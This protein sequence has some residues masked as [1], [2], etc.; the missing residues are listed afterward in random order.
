M[1]RESIILSPFLLGAIA[2]AITL[3]RDHI[4]I[5][6]PRRRTWSSQELESTVFFLKINL[7]RY[8]SL[9][10]LVDSMI[11]VGTGARR[12]SGNWSIERILYVMGLDK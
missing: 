3:R 5:S 7:G 2:F 12:L 1:V 11:M 10:R 8:T 4:S 9:P 6:L